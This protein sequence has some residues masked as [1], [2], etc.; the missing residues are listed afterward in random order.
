MFT[1]TLETA[2]L[3]LRPL[4]VADAEAIFSTWA[5]D[6]DV[7]RYMSYSTHSSVNVTV[8]WLTME[9]QSASKDTHY[10]W[11][12]VLKETGVLIGS[13]G[14]YYTE[15]REA[16]DLGYNIAKPYWGRGLTTEASRGMLDFAVQ[17]LNVREFTAHH[18]KDNLASGKV[19]EKLGFVYQKDGQYTKIDGTQ[20]FESREYRLCV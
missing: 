15:S 2:R 4:T 20:T 5:S 3:I 17:T 16:Y 9:E 1:P 6:P 13:G 10:N 8:E 7:T 11:G 14:I 12:F 19:L 18:A